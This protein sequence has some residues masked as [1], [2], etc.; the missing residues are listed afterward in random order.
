LRELDGSCRTPIGA[1][2]E[3]ANGLLTLHGEILSPDGKLCFSG[4]ISGPAVNADRLGTELGAKLIAD[5]GADFLKLFA[6]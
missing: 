2:T 5:A 4:Q 1:F 6:A 3:Q